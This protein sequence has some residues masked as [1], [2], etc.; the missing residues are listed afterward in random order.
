ML[1]LFSDHKYWYVFINMILSSNFPSLAVISAQY[2]VKCGHEY[3]FL[4]IQ[5]ISLAHFTY[6]WGCIFLLCVFPWSLELGLRLVLFVTRSKGSI[7]RQR[8]PC[9]FM[10]G[11]NA[12]VGMLIVALSTYD[13]GSDLH[14]RLIIFDFSKSWGSFY[15]KG[16]FIQFCFLWWI[17]IIFLWYCLSRSPWLFKS[18][19]LS[20]WDQDLLDLL[21]R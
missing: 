15:V 18:L 6:I 9:I 13:Y 5:S 21:Y 11:S 1:E 19:L 14:N 20:W 8:E 16:A 7:P 4:M 17:S 3:D 2:Y 12:V 10:V